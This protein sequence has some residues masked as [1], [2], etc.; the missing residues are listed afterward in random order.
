MTA[1]SGVG[2]ASAKGAEREAKTK[3][4][5]PSCILTSLRMQISKTRKWNRERKGWEMLLAGL[6]T[7]KAL[8]HVRSNEHRLRAA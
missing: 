7:K 3:E 8:E 6:R 1:P 5:M 4:K 2:D